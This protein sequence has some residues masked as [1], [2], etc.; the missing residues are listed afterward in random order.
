[1]LAGQRNRTVPKTDSPLLTE[2]GII[3]RAGKPAR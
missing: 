1:M 2:S 3:E